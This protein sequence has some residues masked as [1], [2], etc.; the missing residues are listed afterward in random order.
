MTLRKQITNVTIFKSKNKKEWET[1]S[2]ELLNMNKE[3]TLK[4]YNYV[5]DEPYTHLDI[6]TLNNKL[7]KNF[8]LLEISE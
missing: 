7:Y 2:S 6:D 8:N 5:F 1:I 3:D 4:I